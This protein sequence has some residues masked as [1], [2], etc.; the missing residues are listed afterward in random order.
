MS[1]PRYNIAQSVVAIDSDGIQQL[2]IAG[3]RHSGADLSSVDVYTPATKTWFTRTLSVA[4]EYIGT[5]VIGTKGDIFVLYF[6]SALFFAFC[7]LIFVLCL[8]FF[9]CLSVAHG[10]SA[11]SRSHLRWRFDWHK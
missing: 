4:R 2:V 5:G 1:T 6:A 9:H 3:G 7:L 10:L 8:S 11:F